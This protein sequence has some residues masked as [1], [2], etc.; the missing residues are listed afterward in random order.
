[1]G[2]VYDKRRELVT[3]EEKQHSLRYRIMDVVDQIRWIPEFGYAREMDWLHNMHDWMISKK[4]FW[5][6]ALPF[7]QCPDCGHYHVIGDENELADKAKSGFE[8][9]AGHSP[10]RP[11]IDA[12]KIACTSCGGTMSRIADVGNPWLDA[13]IVSFSTLRYRKDR[14]YWRKWYPADWISESFPGQFRNWFYSMLVM[15]TVLDDSPSFLQNFGYATLWAEDGRPMHKS[16]GNSIEFNDAA[17]KMGVDVMRWLYCQ[18]RPE[19]NLLF[20]YGRADVVRRQFLIPLWNVYNFFVTYARLDGWE[21]QQSGFDPRR[22]EGKAPTGT[23]L[24]D[25]WIIG[26]LNQVV[27]LV[28]DALSNSDAYSGT[29]VIEEFLDDLT[30]WYVRRSRRRFWKSEQ[31]TDKKAA[32]ATLY[33]VLVRLAKV[34]APFTPFMTEVMYQNLVRAVVPSAYF[35]IHHCDW[36]EPEEDTID[37]GL[38]ENMS[39]ARRV[40]GLGLSAR[41]GANIKVRQP[42]ARALVHAPDFHASFGPE[43]VDV[44]VDELNVKELAFVEEE[45]RLVTY[46]VLP[47][48]K[49]LGP[50]FGAKFPK[51]RAALS[52]MD[53]SAVVKTLQSGAPLKLEIDDE[54]VE[55]AHEDVLIHTQPAEGLAVSADKG[56]TVAIDAVITPA[57]RAEGLAREVVRRIQTMRKDAGFSIDDRIATFYQTQGELA[58]VMETWRE[59]I[60]AE[61][62]TTNM[63]SAPVPTGAYSERFVVDGLEVTL[64]IRR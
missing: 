48:N 57:L 38:L 61:T 32:Y 54:P 16:W 5:G 31:D 37:P 44:V 1:M 35:S 39:L 59:Y 23:N 17:D 58:D 27:G 22:P 34:L 56:V 26:R 33:Y 20:G 8:Q 45:G 2:P 52:A 36:P 47:D 4:R 19:S 46:R 55:L 63:V 13:G 10:H 42:L 12:V 25:R 7:W 21:P 3:A 30:N 50:R 60:M 51:V 11:F 29:G 64:G 62:L 18:Q 15:G 40:A 53:P 28:T 43:L 6:L 14:E 24:L 9:F 49:Q 41:G